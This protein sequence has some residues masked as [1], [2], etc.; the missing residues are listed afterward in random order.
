MCGERR[1]IWRLGSCFKS[2][3]SSPFFLGGEGSVTVISN[4][5]SFV[6]CKKMHITLYKYL[7][8]NLLNNS[9]LAQKSLIILHWFHYHHTPSQLV[10]FL[11]KYSIFPTEDSSYP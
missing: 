5:S 1:S 7:Y 10:S 9:N 3:N 2:R 11:I 8:G 4:S 6:M